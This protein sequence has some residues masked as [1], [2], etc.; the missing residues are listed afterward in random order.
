MVSTSL[1]LARLSDGLDNKALA[2]DWWLNAVLTLTSGARPEGICVRVCILINRSTTQYTFSLKQ[3]LSLFS[4]SFFS[5]FRLYIKRLVFHNRLK[6]SL[7]FRWKYFYFMRTKHV[8]FF[9]FCFF[10]LTNIWFLIWI[11][12]NLARSIFYCITK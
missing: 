3:K 2:L 9:V 5:F 7:V 4:F 6:N 11:I 8:G 12:I 10:F 1:V